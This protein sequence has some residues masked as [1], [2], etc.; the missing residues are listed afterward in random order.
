M[1]PAHGVEHP[2]RQTSAARTTRAAVVVLLI[3]SAALLVA[4]TLGGWSKLPAVNVAQLVYALIY[5]GAAW[6]VARW[7]RGVLPVA[8]AFAVLLAMVAAVAAPGWFERDQ[9]GFE[10]PALDSGL[11]GVLTLALVP[12]QALLVAFALRGFRQAWHVEVERGPARPRAPRR[13]SA[14]A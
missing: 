8:A 13:T 14:R 7:H 12:V 1:A 11:L 5:L 4:V 3:A 10:E 6:L 9:P 2:N